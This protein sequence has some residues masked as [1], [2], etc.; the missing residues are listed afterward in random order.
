MIRS[1]QT[2]PA[3]VRPL[4][5]ARINM[6]L[7]TLICMFCTVPLL[8]K[9]DD[10][11]V[12]EWIIYDNTETYIYFTNVK[13]N[14]SIAVS[15][16]NL[17]VDYTLVR[18][19]NFKRIIDGTYDRADLRNQILLNGAGWLI[20]R[21]DRS[22]DEER[23]CEVKAIVDKIGIWQEGYLNKFANKRSVDAMKKYL[24]RVYHLNNYNE[25]TPTYSA[26]GVQSQQE[27]ASV[28]ENDEVN[29]N[30]NNEATSIAETEDE[31]LG[32]TSVDAG[33]DSLINALLIVNSRQSEQ[34]AEL[35]ATLLANAK[36]AEDDRITFN[37][38]LAEAN[39]RR[40]VEPDDE[41]QTGFLQ[42]ILETVQHFLHRTMFDKTTW[43][44]GLIA[45]FLGIVS[46]FK[47]KDDG[48][49]RV[50]AAIHG[51]GRFSAILLIGMIFSTF[52]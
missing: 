30:E 42:R 23:F 34:I 22:T 31:E 1:K 43:I 48:H 27:A 26:A 17:H 10:V 21:G 47:K 24:N 16:Y 15:T 19:I 9:A 13:T 51:L 52:I 49:D 39:K 12:P 25:N 38:K 4:I 29:T 40:I 20:T 45:T 32:V 2:N 6:L 11:V 8:V 41:D 3:Q 7:L 50:L 46:Y 18:A 36:I 14:D 35:R 37:K 5:E 33:K 28:I 44:F